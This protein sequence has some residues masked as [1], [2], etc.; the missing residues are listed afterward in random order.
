MRVT[1]HGRFTDHPRVLFSRLGYHPAPGF[2]GEEAYARR[3]GGLNYPRFH[4]YLHAARPGE[5]AFRI[6]LDQ[7]RPS[8]AGSH[9]HAAEYDGQALEAEVTRI[10]SALV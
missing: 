1:L 5:I 6:H 9:A 10:R 3:V 2:R 8:Y 4:V 7:K